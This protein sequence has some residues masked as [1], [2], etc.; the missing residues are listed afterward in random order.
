MFIKTYGI[1]DPE[2]D[3][4]VLF[5]CI[6]IYLVKLNVSARGQMPDHNSD[7]LPPPHAR[8]SVYSTDTLRHQM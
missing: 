6:T 2:G 4:E 7:G 1:S 8:L 3:N 5:V